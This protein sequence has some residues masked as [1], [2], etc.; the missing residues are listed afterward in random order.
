MGVADSLEA[1]IDEIGFGRWQVLFMTMALLSHAIG[2]VQQLGSTF[3]SAPVPFRC[4]YPE[5]IQTA[6]ETNNTSNGGGLLDL[7]EIL[8]PSECLPE[9]NP[10]DQMYHNLPPTTINKRSVHQHETGLPSCPIVEY[11]T[12]VFDST[13]ITEWDL[14]C[15]NANFRPLFQMTYSIGAIIGSL[16]CGQ[17]S[18]S[19]G[20]KRTL[21]IGGVITL[22][23]IVGSSLAPWY[24]AMIVMRIFTGVG[25]MLT[26]FP[27]YTLISEV[28]PSSSRT[29]SAMIPGMTYFAFMS[30]LSYL[31]YIIPDWRRLLLISNSPIVLLVPLYFVIDESPRWLVQQGRTSEAVEILKK[32]A[33]KNRV[34]LSPSTSTSLE[35]LSLMSKEMAKE[36]FRT[37]LCESAIDNSIADDLSSWEMLKLCFSYIGMRTILIVT[38]FLWL[39]KRS[40]YIGIVLNANNFTST[41]AF[42]YVAVSGAMGIVGLVISLPVS[43]RVPRRLF[44]GAT[45]SLGG[46]LL[47]AELPIPAE[48]WILKWSMVMV[49]FCLVSAAFQINYIYAAE[50]FPTVFRTRGFT[51]T[52][53]IGSMGEMVI[54]IVTE[55]VVQ[56]QWWAASVTFGLAGI[57]ASLLLPLLP[58]TMNKK[59][60]ETLEDVEDRYW[61]EFRGR[62]KDIVVSKDE[63]KGKASFQV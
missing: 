1:A 19:L 34:E 31:A 28:C 53:F 57:I 13:V 16:F 17:L 5:Y 3:L 21:Q 62:G 51:F 45:L 33:A 40:L 63:Q 39:L 54:P 20:R 29:I 2:P 38:P 15:E 24:Y 36:K 44:I 14:V 49:S 10:L 52:N 4:S 27:T 26:L 12:S 60:P 37:S 48:Y 23:M 18:D 59:M 55:I 25:T 22:T 58:E 30:V 50:L 11:D 56:Y 43:V 9:R 46:I 35:K 47:L 41:S 6:D 8:Y 61:N 42:Q 7:D 32:A